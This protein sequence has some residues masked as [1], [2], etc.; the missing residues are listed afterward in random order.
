MNDKA[1]QE[2]GGNIYKVMRQQGNVFGDFLDYSANINPLGLSEKVRQSMLEAMERVIH[3]PDAEAAELKVAIRDAYHIDQS[4]IT[5]GNG[6]VELLY[7]LCHVLRPKNVLITAPAFSEYERAALACGAEVNY[8]YLAAEQDFAIDI[9]AIV[10]TLPGIDIVFIGNPNNPTG[11]LLNL[12]QVEILLEA[13]A[14]QGTYVVMDESFLDFL[15]DDTQFSCRSFFGRY[16]NLIIIHSLTKF[17]AIPGLRLGFALANPAL[18]MVLHKSK[19][20]WNVNTLAQAAGVA[21]LRDLEYRQASRS[22]IQSA[23]QQ[24]AEDLLSIPGIRP[25]PPT[26]NFIL[27]DITKTGIPPAVLREKLLQHNIMI[28]DCSSYP[29]L[30]DGYYVRFAVKLP[31]QNQQLVRALQ[32]VIG[33]P[34]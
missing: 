26:V 7:I 27:A 9:N 30:T 13:A 28:R 21:A 19:D 34:L 8:C 18:T 3:Y 15:P 17:Y 16:D 1:S 29:G 6:A 5:P 24:L 33:E 22:V 2:H 20:P 12:S 11:G 4:L 23:K 25:V 31:E 14:R 32:T 10:R